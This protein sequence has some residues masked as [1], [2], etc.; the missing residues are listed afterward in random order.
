MYLRRPCQFD[1]DGKINCKI[2]TT[3]SVGKVDIFVAPLWSP[4]RKSMYLHHL[5]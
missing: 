3:V 1:I 2:E 4:F 5:V